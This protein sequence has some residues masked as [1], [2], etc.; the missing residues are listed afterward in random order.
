[1]LLAI[2]NAKD[3]TGEAIKDNIRKVARAAARRSTTP[4]TASRRSRP[5]RRST[6]T[7]PRG[8]CDFD[9]MGDILDCKFRYEQ[10]KAGKF[11]LVKIA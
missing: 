7:A 4:S 9:D 10:I 3:A 5:A 1:M 8:P 6:T 2:A 11:T